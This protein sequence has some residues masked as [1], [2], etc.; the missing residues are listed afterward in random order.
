MDDNYTAVKLDTST[1]QIIGVIQ[2]D[3]DIKETIYRHECAITGDTPRGLYYRITDL[4][5]G[6]FFAKECDVEFLIHKL[7][8]HTAFTNDDRLI[9]L[10]IADVNDH[11]ANSDQGED[12]MGSC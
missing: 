6:S 1:D 11:A 3:H 10:V 8:S 9:D 5:E 2:Y 4:K 7:E 12:F